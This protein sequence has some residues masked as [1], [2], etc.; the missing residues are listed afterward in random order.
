V[1]SRS[2]PIQNPRD[3]IETSGNGDPCSSTCFRRDRE[4]HRSFYN[5]GEIRRG[6]SA[7][8]RHI[9]LE[10]IGETPPQGEEGPGG[11]EIRTLQ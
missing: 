9:T 2:R 10:L 5:P 7:L 3:W 6:I 1:G 8:G 4:A 11:K